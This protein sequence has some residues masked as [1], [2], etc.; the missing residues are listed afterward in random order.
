MPQVVEIPNLTRDE[1]RE[2]A[3][4]FSIDAIQVDTIPQSDGRFTVRATYPDG[5][6]VPGAFA[7]GFDNSGCA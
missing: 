7:S 2:R 3:A 6:V 5:T 1:A 4:N